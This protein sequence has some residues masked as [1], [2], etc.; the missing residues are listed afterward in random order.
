LNHALSNTINRPRSVMPDA[1]P[2]IAGLGVGCVP[3]EN[4]PN[5][6]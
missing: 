6:K 3:V 4:D 2:D 1:N 5:R